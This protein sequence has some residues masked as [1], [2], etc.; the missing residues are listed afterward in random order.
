[1]IATITILLSLLCLVGAV[2]TQPQPVLVPVKATRRPLD[3]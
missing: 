3:R 2:G 1:M